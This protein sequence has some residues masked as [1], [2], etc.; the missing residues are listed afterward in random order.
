MQTAFL[1]A[2][3]FHLCYTYT[4]YKE[5]SAAMEWN[6][7]YDADRQLTGKLHK[8]GTPWKKDEFGL[9]VC[10][11]VYDGSG[12]LLLT[13]RAKGKSFAGT[14]ENSGGAAQAG[15]TS[16]QAIARELFEETGIRAE[17]AAFELIDTDRDRNNFY[18]FYCLKWPIHLKDIVLLPGE[19]DG[20]QWVSYGKMNWMIRTGRICKIIARQYKRQE[21]LLKAR[22]PHKTEG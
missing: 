3:S 19:T 10:V 18:D 1:I 14:W 15:E 13:R 22:N 17:E 6:D 12:H 8:R 7:V 20:V 4:H 11:W 21:N 5:R 2:F 16:R 9:V